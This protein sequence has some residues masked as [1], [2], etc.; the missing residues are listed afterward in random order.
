MPIASYPSIPFS[1]SS[2]FE[3]DERILESR[4]GDGYSQRVGDGIN[5]QFQKGTLVHENISQTDYN[6]LLAFWK[7]VGRISVFN[8][9]DPKDGTTL[10]VRFTSP[11]SVSA[12][13]GNIYSV[14]AS[15]EQDFGLTT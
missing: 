12:L 14:S 13:S 10:K 15:V 5:T 4:F 9:T 2:T 6:T 3:Y 8:I 1:Q 7:S 11:W